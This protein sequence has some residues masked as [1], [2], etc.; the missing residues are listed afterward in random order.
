M[1]IVVDTSVW[2][3]A[4][5][6]KSKPAHAAIKLFQELIA[7]GRV[8]LLGAIR[9]EILSGIKHSEQFIKLKDYLRAFPDLQLAVDD[10]ELAAEYFNVCRSRGIQG[11]NTDFLICAAATRQKYHV[12]KIDKDFGSFTTHLPIKL[13]EIGGH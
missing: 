4:L 6:R 8:V 7:E 2:S 9:Q 13:I 11:S 12:L 3:L 1:N 5:R 10:Y